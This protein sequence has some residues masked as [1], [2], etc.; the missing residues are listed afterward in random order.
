MEA[1]KEGKITASSAALTVQT[2]SATERDKQ[3]EVAKRARKRAE[4]EVPLLLTETEA[5]DL[6]HIILSAIDETFERHNA[7]PTRG[8]FGDVRTI[9]DE[10]SG[11]QI[12]PVG[13][14]PLQTPK[15]MKRLLT[16]IAVLCILASTSIAAPLYQTTSLVG[17][18]R[19][20]PAQNYSYAVRFDNAFGGHWNLNGRNQ[21]NKDG[22][23]T[24]SFSGTVSDTAVLGTFTRNDFDWVSDGWFLC[25]HVQVICSSFS[26]TIS[27]GHITGF[28]IYR[29]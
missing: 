26:I 23:Y 25:S 6:E 2:P 27:D 20:H 24:E 5:S 15:K 9:H 29:P 14:R 18:T 3:I 1:M 17:N 19:C 11:P 8:G 16:P 4:N 21:L 10:S 22:T 28:A 13:K 7:M 12:T